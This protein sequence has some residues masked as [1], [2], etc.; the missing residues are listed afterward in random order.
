MS[1]YPTVCTVYCVHFF[2]LNCTA[3][4][5]LNYDNLFC[6]CT[7]LQF[8][9]NSNELESLRSQKIAF[10]NSIHLAGESTAASK[11]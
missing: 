4:F 1:F 2:F 10:K 8:L 6:F 5:I 7:C 11:D 9:H 3:Y